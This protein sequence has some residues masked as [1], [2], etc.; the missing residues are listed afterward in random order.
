MTIH[1]I[2]LSVS[3]NKVLNK[4]ARCLSTPQVEAS[5]LMQQLSLILLELDKKKIRK[6]YKEK[7]IVNYSAVIIRNIAIKKD[8]LVMVR[9]DTV[10]QVED[11][12]DITDIDAFKEI[13]LTPVYDL[14][15]GPIDTTNY[16]DLTIARQW[17]KGESI[18][19]ISKKTRIPTSAIFQSLKATKETIKKKCLKQ[20]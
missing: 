3:K 9:I 6:L 14:L 15:Q 17:A 5:D 7:T 2:V 11:T 18:A 19:T 8:K 20:S 10:P 12:P 16:F 4:Y 13:D 1:N